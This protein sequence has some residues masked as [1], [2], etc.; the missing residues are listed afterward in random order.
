M[1][2]KIIII[3]LLVI[4][5]ILSSCSLGNGRIMF[6]NDDETRA[7]KRFQQVTKALKN[8]DKEA[9]KKIFSKKAL[10]E[11]DDFEEG[12]DYLFKFFQGDI[13]SYELIIGPQVSDD[14]EYGKQTKEVK[15]WY[16]VKT[17]KEDY[18]FFFRII[19]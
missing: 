9:L 2:K 15:T 3:F 13:E 14:F 19:L 11:A 18:I 5:V 17:D 16:N 10:D 12:M 1:N 4:T 7:D 6:F 8:Q